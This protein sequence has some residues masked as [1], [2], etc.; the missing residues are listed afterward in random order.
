MADRGRPSWPLALLDRLTLFWRD[1]W[2]R[3][4]VLG[5]DQRRACSTAAFAPERIDVAARSVTGAIGSSHLPLRRRRSSAGY[6]ILLY[7]GNFGV[8][9]DYETFLSRLS[10]SI[11]ARAAAQSACG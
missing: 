3:F 1:A 6:R 5:E 8:A 9:H 11:I 10:W 2:P 4:E 7:S